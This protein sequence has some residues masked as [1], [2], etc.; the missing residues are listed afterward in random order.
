MTVINDFLHIFGAFML[1]MILA[2][3]FINVGLLHDC[4]Q[5]GKSQMWFGGPIKCEVVK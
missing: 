1:V 5:F 3:I 2:C 4:D